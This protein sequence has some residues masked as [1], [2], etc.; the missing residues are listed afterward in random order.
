MEKE[1]RIAWE[2]K[3]TQDEPPA[4]SSSCP[5]HID[6]RQFMQQLADGD[7]KAAYQTLKKT[8]PFP[9]IL[10]RICDHPCEAACRREEA[11]EA[12]AI[13]S[14]ERFCV[15]Q[16]G[17][18]DPVKP[19]PAKSKKV[20]VLGAGLAGLTAALDLLSKGIRVAIYEQDQQ[21]GSALHSY[22][23]Q[24][25]PAAV[26][27]VELAVLTA[28]RAD[29][30]LGTPCDSATFAGLAE[31][32][33][34]IFVDGQATANWT[35]PLQREAN[36]CIVHDTLTGATAEQG[37]FAG[38]EAD[39]SQG[40][41]PIMEAYA[42][43]KGAL[44]IERFLQKATIDYNRE[45]EGP[46]PTRLHTNL[47]DI[48]PSVRTLPEQLTEETVRAEASRC[49]QC[50]CLECVKHCLY[51]QKFKKHPKPYIRQIFNNELVMHGAAH[52]KNKFVNS[53][54]LCGLCKNV[55]PNDLFM[56]EICLN[57]RETMVEEKF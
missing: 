6:V 50:E 26:I 9:G 13:G 27:D 4:C 41:S 15:E 22:S 17:A 56:G 31:T 44:S 16:Y 54:S 55:C 3:C 20:A 34:A 45:N 52:S 7:N 38:G 18:P 32:Y 51:L 40:Y 19:L 48:E 53:C 5:L 49:I 23:E 14:L 35:L 11:G 10:G 36:G 28:L 21:L 25:L 37:I 24:V 30:Q 33:D 46:Y 42:G 8:M 39:P 47:K 1:Q 2:A 43:R 29:L 12:L 57:S